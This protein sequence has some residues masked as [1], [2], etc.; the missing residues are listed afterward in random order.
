MYE[1]DDK[2]KLLYALDVLESFVSEEKKRLKY[3]KSIP[4]ENKKKIIVARKILHEVI[5]QEEDI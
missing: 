4:P 5:E 1:R 3:G 2:K